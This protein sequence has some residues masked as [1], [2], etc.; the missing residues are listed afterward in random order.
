MKKLIEIALNIYLLLATIAVKNFNKTQYMLLV[1]DAGTT[2][3][4]ILMLHKPICPQKGV[5]RKAN[6]KSS[7]E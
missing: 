5:E 6:L 1:P 2:N 3:E 4:V 7:R